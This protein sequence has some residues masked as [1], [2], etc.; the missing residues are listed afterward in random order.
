M[1]GLSPLLF[2]CYFF[3]SSLSLSKELPTESFSQLP[4][5]TSPKLSPTGKSIAYIGNYRDPGLAILTTYNLSTGKVNFLAKSDNEKV[6]INWFNWANEKTLIVS[7]WFAS[8]RGG[9]D[10]TETRLIAFD[11]DGEEIIERALIKPRASSQIVSQFQDNVLSYLP[12][13]PDHILIAIDLEKV[14]QPSVYKV[15]VN[16]G[17]K[18]RIEKGKLDIRDWL[19]DQQGNL[20]LGKALNYKTGEASTRVRIGDDKKWH[21]IFE[22]NALNE[23][24]ITPLGFGLDPNILYYR[25][26]K[27]DKLALFT[28]NLETKEETLIF[29]DKNYDVDGRLIYSRKSRDVIGLYHRNSENG[30]I[31]WDNAL[32]NFQ[33]S[34]NH[35]LPDTHNYLLDFSTDEKT[36]ILYTENDYTPGVYY[37]GNRQNKTLDLLFKEY[38]GISSEELTAHKFLTYTARDGEKI[39]GYLTIPK[40]LESK[41]LPTIIHPHGGPGARESAGFDYWTSFFT[42]RGYAVFRPNFRGSTGYGYEF[43]QSQMKGWGLTMQDDLTDAA[44]WLVEKGIADPE[45]MCIV[46]ASYGGYAAA[47]AAV[48]TPDLFKCAISFAGVSDL[49]QLVTESRNYTNSRFVKNQIGNKSKDL[50]ARSPY[51]QA[52]KV[53]IPMLFIHGEQDRVVDVKQS[54]MM[55]KKL[56]KLGKD[57]TYIE[58]EKGDHYLSLQKNRDKAFEAMDKFLR[59]HLKQ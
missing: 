35:A 16:T 42:N 11:V 12:N 2:F 57:V 41:E 31:Y 3:L 13:D 39:E 30:R 50:K 27:G 55:S 17:K 8:K 1:K 22:Y 52:E 46:G 20:R 5:H 4:K 21:K 36:Y 38:P 15:N 9:V 10:T 40:G 25:A 29:E 54:R 14:N 24:A 53:A 19:V 28:L 34:I 44:N 23:P 58:L 47:M 49:K 18:K 59:Q 43:A 33:K 26:Y 37:L 32:S 48:K 56:F 51:Y 45:R 6:K 7:L